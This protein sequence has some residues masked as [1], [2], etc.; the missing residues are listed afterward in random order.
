MRLHPRGPGERARG[1]RQPGERDQLGAPYLGEE[2][3]PLGWWLREVDP[4]GQLP[5]DR[6]LAQAE[7]ARLEWQE[8]L[9]RVAEDRDRALGRDS[10]PGAPRDVAVVE[11]VEVVETRTIRVTRAVAHPPW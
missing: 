7:R 10:D 9:L 3:P 1:D 4:H 8:Q 5:A 6:R 2:T 11:V